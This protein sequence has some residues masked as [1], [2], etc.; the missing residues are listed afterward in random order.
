VKDLR[1]IEN[2]V[3]LL[4]FDLVGSEVSDITSAEGV[5]QH[6][7][8]DALTKPDQGYFA[9]IGMNKLQYL[10]LSGNQVTDIAPI[11]QMT[12]MNSL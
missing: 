3:A 4:Q 1:G 9:A 6:P 5:G 12:A 8:A 10:E 2:C 11:A 7:V